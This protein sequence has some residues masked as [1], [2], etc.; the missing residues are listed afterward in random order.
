MFFLNSFLACLTV[1]AE[2][3]PEPLRGEFL[4][5]AFGAEVSAAIVFLK[6]SCLYLQSFADFGH[7]FSRNFRHNP[8]FRA[9]SFFSFDIVDLSGVEFLELLF[10]L[11]LLG[12]DV[13][14]PF[15]GFRPRPLCLALA[16]ANRPLSL[17]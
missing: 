13:G 8:S 3:A 16:F 4:G 9:F 14:L 12:L 6:L 15:E 17:G 10:E 2:G 7:F 11:G 5:V 1:F